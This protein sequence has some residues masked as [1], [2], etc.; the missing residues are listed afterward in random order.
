MAKLLISLILLAIMLTGLTI[1]I[2]RKFQILP[3]NKKHFLVIGFCILIFNLAAAHI[4]ATIMPTG[5]FNEQIYVSRAV[6]SS[7]GGLGLYVKSFFATPLFL[8]FFYWMKFLRRNEFVNWDIV[9]LLIFYGTLLD[10]V[11]DAYYLL[12]LKSL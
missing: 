9:L 1:L 10:V 7:F 12:L 8:I 2:F 11:V 5:L 6:Y 3:L 4:T